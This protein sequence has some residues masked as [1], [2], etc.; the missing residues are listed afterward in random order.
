[1][2]EIDVLVIGRSCLDHIAVVEKFPEED[3]KMPLVLRITE[4]GGQG[5]TSSCCISR[6][7][8]KVAY[9][10]KLGDDAEGS[11]CLKRLEDFGVNTR[12]VETVKNG[13]T[14]VA[15][16][17]ATQSNGKRTIVYEKSRLPKIH[18]H[19]IFKT[20]N[21]GQGSILLD[22][23]VTYLGKDLA[24]LRPHTFKIVYDCERWRDGISEMMVI[25]DFFYSF[26]G[27]FKCSRTGF[28]EVVIFAKDDP[29]ARN[30]T[31]RV[32]CDLRGKG[33]VFF[34]RQSNYSDSR[35]ESRRQGYHRCG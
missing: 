31:G 25:A 5:G 15:Y 19:Q 11:F 22:P 2:E 24:S 17:L 28:R 16:I 30:D 33:R 14:P 20:L 18:L 7:G 32:N 35:T 3:Q 4:A 12:H 9:V 1:M 27:F 8:G 23:E 29:V 34:S 13:K 6:L 26:R 10:G 21:V